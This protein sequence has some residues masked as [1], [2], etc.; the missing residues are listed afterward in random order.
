MTKLDRELNRAIFRGKIL[1][2]VKTIIMNPKLL[3]VLPK[4]IS[5]IF[6][7]LKKRFL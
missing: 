2:T 5:F 1:G 7:Q 4:I 3:K 6:K